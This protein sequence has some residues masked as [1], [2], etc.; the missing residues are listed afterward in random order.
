MGYSKSSSNRAVYT[1]SFSLQETRKVLNKQSKLTPKTTRERRTNKTQSRKKEIIKIRGEINGIEMKKI[2]A[3]INENK[4][5][6]FEKIS[7][8]DKPLA[9]FIT[10]K[11]R[12]LKSIKL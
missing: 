8:I 5:Q 9:A 3:K 7:K 11:N 1:N 2:I 6:F 12:R 4:S 10:E